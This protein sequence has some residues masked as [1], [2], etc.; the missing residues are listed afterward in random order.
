VGEQRRHRRLAARR[1]QLRQ[2]ATKGHAVHKRRRVPLWQRAAGV[3]L[4]GLA[5]MLFGGMALTDA[6]TTIDLS[7]RGVVA[8][9][10]VVD[11]VDVFRGRDQVTVRFVAGDGQEIQAET[12]RF[13]RLPEV[14][15]SVQIRYD[16]ND[17]TTFESASYPHDYW[18]TVVEGAL[19]VAMLLLVWAVLTGR[20]PDWLHG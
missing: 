1:L 13:R 20:G 18:D 2:D 3:I 6:T 11:V 4:G 5:A 15:T 17:P 14:G 16:P 8:T 19:A 10:V 7:R 12:E 9:G